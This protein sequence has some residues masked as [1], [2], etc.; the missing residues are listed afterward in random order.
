M[1]VAMLHADLPGATNGGVAHQVSRLADALCCRGHDVVVFTYTAPPPS[2]RYRVERLSLPR[3]VFDSKVG[4]AA[5]V[6]V[7]FAAAP[8]RAFDVVHVHGDSHLLVR[9]SIP[10]V[11]TF[12]GSAREEAR[13]AE[14]LRRKAMQRVVYACERMARHTATLT[15]GVSRNT[16]ASLGALDAVIPCGV[17]CELF[18]PG[19]KSA[20]P[21]ILF[22][23]TIGGRKRGRLVVDAF[24]TQIRPSLP[25]CELW[26][27]AD[28]PV[29]GE[30]IRSWHCP[31][32][33]VVADL[34]RRA[35]LLVHPSSYE[36]FGVPYIEAMAS[37]TAIVSTDNPGAHELLGDGEAG[38][39]VGEDELGARVLALLA[40]DARRQAMERSGRERSLR[41]A[42]P[43]VAAAY[44]D[45]YE[46]ARE[47]IRAR[48]GAARCRTAS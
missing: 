17:D 45:V 18:H 16:E 1:R 19:P 27:V 30:G 7:G 6:P 10:V 22:V 36:G 41:F 12:H 26:M 46:R 32:D 24:R 48:T 15:V 43:E 29:A 20:H 40:D 8:Y 31:P 5:G 35:W 14:R 23:G 4:R 13:H 11:R 38:C 28:Q 25:G 2:V 21:S 9:R 3:R 34:C 39:V 42:W 33:D 44:E 47:H 37:G